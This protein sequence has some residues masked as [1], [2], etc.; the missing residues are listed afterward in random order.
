MELKSLKI[1]GFKSFP[2]ET[3][4][5]FEPGITAIVGP[6][7]CGK[8]NVVDA[9]RWTLGEQSVHSLRAG[10]TEQLIFNGSQTRKPLGMA[11]VSLTFSNPSHYTPPS[12]GGSDGAI[13][14]FSEITVTR[15]IFRSGESEYFINKAPCRLKDIL[16]VFMDTGLGVNA[17]SVISQD[18]VDMILNAKPEERRYIFEEAAGITK[19]SKRK[20]EALRK[21]ELTK[22]N[23]LR[24]QDIIAELERQSNALKRQVFK[25]KR[26]K[27]VKEELQNL[28]VTD[29]FYQYKTFQEGKNRI[30]AAIKNFD[31]EKTNIDVVFKK[32]EKN[33]KNLQDELAKIET[34]LEE[35]REEQLRLL[36]EIERG[37]STII[38]NEER[39][40]NLSSKLEEENAA[41]IKLN[42]ELAAVSQQIE[43]YLKTMES[44]RKD[45]EAL[46]VE[47]EEFFKKISEISDAEKT[48][49]KELEEKNSQ[50]IEFLSEQARLKNALENSKVNIHNLEVRLKKLAEEKDGMSVRK[51][52]LE[53]E[54]NTKNQELG[55]SKKEAAEIESRIKSFEKNLVKIEEVLKGI[56]DNIIAVKSVLHMKKSHLSALTEMYSKDEGLQ[57]SVKFIMESEENSN[58]HGLIFNILEVSEEFQKAIEVAL[59]DNVQGLIV[60]DNNAVSKLIGLLKE[61]ER[62]RA[63]FFPAE[64]IHPHTK[65][66]K[67]FGV[68]VKYE[69]AIDKI[70]FPQEFAGIFNYLLDKV[71]IAKDWEEAMKLYY[72]LSEDYKIVTRDGDLL[73]PGGFIQG[74][75]RN[76]MHAL[77]GRKERISKMGEEVNS[78]EEK[79][80]TVE[81]KK[82]EELGKIQKIEQELKEKRKGSANKNEKGANL[83]KEIGS[84]SEKLSELQKRDKF[85]ADEQKNIEQEKKQAQ[86]KLKETQEQLESAQIKIGEYNSAIGS[87]KKS[88]ESLSEEEKKIKDISEEK[89]IKLFALRQSRKNAED[90]FKNLGDKKKT[91]LEGI[92]NISA[93]AEEVNKRIELLK[94]EIEESGARLI[95]QKQQIE[96]L[97]QRLEELKDKRAVIGE[98]CKDKEKFIREKGAELE[99]RRN[100]LQALEI[101]KTKIETEI[102]DL[103]ENIFS[104][105]AVSLEDFTPPETETVQEHIRERIE[106]L[107]EKLTGMGNVNLAAIEEEEELTERY[108]FYLTQQKDLLDSEQSLQ[109]TITQINSTA[110]SLFR[111][112]LEKVRKEFRDVFINLFQGGEADL[113]LVGSQ[114]VLEAGIDIIVSPPGKKL[115]SVSLMS[116]GERALTSIAL[117]FALFKVR[118]SPFCILDEID[119]PLDETNIGRFTNFL[120]DLAT[121]TQFIIISHNKKTLSISEILYGVTMEDPGVSK[122]VSVK[123]TSS[124]KDSKDANKPA[125][126]D[127]TGS[128][129]ISDKTVAQTA[130]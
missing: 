76:Q 60:K 129:E 52:S 79:L 126:P 114:D 122:V 120:K 42:E 112:T 30:D 40:K 107:K 99:N 4:F 119:A 6:N 106:D 51:L 80:R 117:L 56:E 71:V 89:R 53:N 17:Y 11:E 88:F 57:D 20:N 98:Q 81:Q 77:L 59:R 68:G 83:E 104:N 118:P 19:Y 44:A 47:A 43:T 5:E 28:Q 24:I 78:L 9:I 38:I 31:K 86:D 15:R 23:L 55:N 94:K 7:G 91:L 116:G 61:K 34:E 124:Q 74:G 46:S 85:I 16:E 97:K 63:T 13:L 26:Y 66:N 96:S 101:E 102:K 125:T 84:I 2:D 110:R 10:Q 35:K 58:I 21:L 12:L 72:S 33:F 65:N 48:N 70:K 82:T 127:E 108:N 121:N 103:K 123:F 130:K 54:L 64:N 22:Q 27:G 73:H 8:S 18:Q 90:A 14:T 92:P 113:K 41:K 62:G 49:E 37:N 128:T 75:S 93:E 87:I 109:D 39:I 3:K 100:A 95:E 32:E 105:H 50:L 115:A 29:S 1:F 111:D 25:A 67:D 45:E 69:F 36:S